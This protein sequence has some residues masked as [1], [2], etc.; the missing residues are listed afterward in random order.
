VLVFGVE[1][2]GRAVRGDQGQGAYVRSQGGVDVVVLAVHVGGDRPA[3][4]H[5]FGP[6]GDG[7]EGT[8]RQQVRDEVAQW[9]PRRC[10]HLAPQ[11]VETHSAREPR[12]VQDQTTGVLR[13]VSVGA[14][15]PSGQHT[16]GAGVGQTRGDLFRVTRTYHVRRAGGG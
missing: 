5:V 14:T 15:Q 10:G 4:G 9:G 16:P 1:P 2:V 3:Q 6:G 12:A 8:V 11:R 7:Q 13:G